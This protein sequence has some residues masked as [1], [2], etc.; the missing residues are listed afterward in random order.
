MRAATVTAFGAPDG[1]APRDWP[2]PAPGPGQAL[3]A[4]E[5]AE[6]NY[7]D[8]LVVAG[9][10]QVLPPLPFIP[11]KTAVGRVL[12]LGP[13]TDGPPIGTRVIAA[14]EHGA[15]AERAVATAAVL[16]PVPENL[17]SV[18]AAA[19]GLAAQTAWFALTVRARLEAGDSVLVL[20]AS[21]AVG[22]GAV[23]IA[24]ALGAARVIGAVRNDA[25]ADLARA[26]GAHAVLRLDRPALRDSLPDELRACGGVVD[27]VVDPIGGEATTAALR[28]LAW[29]GRLVVLGF[30]GGDIACL[31]ANYLLVKNIAV[32]GLQWSDYRERAPARVVSAWRFLFRLHES[33]ALTPRIGRVLPLA[34]TSEALVGLAAGGGGERTL[35]RIT[36]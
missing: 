14:M 25:G 7:P 36:E 19:L 24:R 9:R 18:C 5:V 28:C 34:Q 16:A 29:G 31:R 10:Y 2:E 32:L 3:I 1:I 6:V 33:G 22:L 21:G 35:L 12:A 27:V 15:F 30:A 11:G 8:L 13:D 20:G 17:P 23:A 4:V 26:A